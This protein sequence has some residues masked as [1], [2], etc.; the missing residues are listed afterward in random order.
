MEVNIKGNVI[1]LKENQLT[2][3]FIFK[4]YVNL[5]YQ[6]SMR[7]VHLIMKLKVYLGSEIK[8]LIGFKRERE[9]LKD[10]I[11]EKQG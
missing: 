5:H 9:V 2:L 11:L 6:F 1:I 4:K 8:P 7:S 10:M 3:N